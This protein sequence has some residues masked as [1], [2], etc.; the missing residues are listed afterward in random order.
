MSDEIEKQIITEATRQTPV[1]E[2][3][4]RM[5]R[6]YELATGQKPIIAPRP[7]TPTEPRAHLPQWEGKMRGELP[8]DH[9]ERLRRIKSHK[10]MMAR[11]KERD[12]AVIAAEAAVEQK[13]R[14][15]THVVIG[16]N[17]KVDYEDD[18]GTR[19][20]GDYGG[21]EGEV[22]QTYV[23]SEGVRRHIIVHRNPE[24]GKSDYAPVGVRECGLTPRGDGPR[25]F[26]LKPSS[27]DPHRNDGMTQEEIERASFGGL[28]AR[29]LANK[30]CGL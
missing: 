18:D 9:P 23:D 25:V 16:S 3:I 21:V 15:G 5:V 20:T 1:P 27:V 22:F 13:I 30:M 8:D 11:E 19:V 10:K 6:E 29:E 4:N 2:S 17:A 7:S 26:A 24:T 28:T 12:Q 14:L